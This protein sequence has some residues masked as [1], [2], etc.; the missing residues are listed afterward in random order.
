MKTLT[1][2]ATL[3][4]AFTLSP[5]VQADD[6]ETFTCK[7]GYGINEKH[8]ATLKIKPS[9]LLGTVTVMD[10]TYTAL[11]SQ[12]GSHKQWDF[13]P[14]NQY[15]VRVDQTGFAYYFDFALADE[16]SASTLITCV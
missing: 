7:T 13:G 4:L 6:G 3:V 10:H 15:S 2:I 16:V 8:V 5:T 12:R 1:L 9:K 11:V 14:E